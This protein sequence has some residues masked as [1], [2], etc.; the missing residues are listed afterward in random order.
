MEQVGSS[1]ESHKRQEALW[2]EGAGTR[3]L[4]WAKEQ[5]SCWQVISLRGVA[6]VY[7]ADGLMLSRRLLI[8]WLKIPGGPGE[9]GAKTVLKPQFGVGL[10][11]CL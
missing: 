10:L 9:E 7:P 2:I 11:P 1:P 3:S 6:G 8:A 5:V 4:F